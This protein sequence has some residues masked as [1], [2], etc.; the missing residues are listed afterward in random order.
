M[1]DVSLAIPHI[2]GGGAPEPPVILRK[3]INP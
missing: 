3:K 1:S 2:N